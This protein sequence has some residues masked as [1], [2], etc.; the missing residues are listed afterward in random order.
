MNIYKRERENDGVLMKNYNELGKKINEDNIK[1]V[2]ES[3]MEYSCILL[4]KNH[5]HNFEKI[6]IF[7]LKVQSFGTYVHLFGTKVH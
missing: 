3:P 6:M 2:V 5:C 4:G 7:S 1:V